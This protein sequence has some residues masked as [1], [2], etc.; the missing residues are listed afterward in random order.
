MYIYLIN[1]IVLAIRIAREEQEKTRSARLRMQRHLESLRSTAA[2]SESKPC[3]EN[4]PVL[5]DLVSGT[6]LVPFFSSSSPC[7]IYIVYIIYIIYILPHHLHSFSCLFMFL[8][9]L[10]VYIVFHHLF[11]FLLVMFTFSFLFVYILFPF[12]CLC[13][14]SSLFALLILI[15]IPLSPHYI[16]FFSLLFTFLLIIYTPLV[17]S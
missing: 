3:A 6:L 10:S 1:V 7:F 12:P 14:S 13:S 17:V 11:T 4:T 16:V 5:F 15:Y 9:L 2:I 8:F